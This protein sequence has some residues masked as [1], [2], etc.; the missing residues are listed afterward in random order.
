[1]PPGT[2]PKT[3]PQANRWEGRH[4]INPARVRRSRREQPAP[5]HGPLAETPAQREQWSALRDG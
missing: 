4:W 2:A 3:W 5:K 1:M